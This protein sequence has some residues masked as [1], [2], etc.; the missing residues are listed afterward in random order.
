MGIFLG[1]SE[2]T[3]PLVFLLTEDRQSVSVMLDY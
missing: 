1:P 3:D 2:A